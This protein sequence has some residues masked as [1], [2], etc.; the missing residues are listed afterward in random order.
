MV[1]AVMRNQELIKKLRAL[2]MSAASFLFLQFFPLLLIAA[3]GDVIF[4]DDF[5]RATL[6]ADWTVDNSG[7]GD[8]GISAQTANSGTRSLY[9]RWNIVSVTSKSFDLSAVAGAELAIWVRRGDDAFSEDPDNNEDITVE[10]LNNVG[11]WQQLA[12]YVGND[13]PGQIFTPTFYLP[14]GALHSGFQIRFSQTGGSGS[15]WDYWH[16]DDVILTETAG[17]PTLVF[18][19]CDDFESGMN[20]WQVLTAGGDAGT[21]TY[22]FNSASNSLYL[23]WGVVNVTSFDIDLSAVPTAYLNFWLRRGADS[24]SEDPDNN[25]DF[26]VEYFNNSGVWTNLETF[27]GNGSAGEIFNRS[28]LLPASALHSAFKVRFSMSGGS[29]SDWDYWHVDDVCVEGPPAPAT[30][31]ALYH[32]DEASWGSVTDSSGNGNDGAVVGGAVPDNTSPAVAGNP[33]TCGYADIPFNDSDNTYDAI[34]TGID[35]DSGIGNTGT[36]DFWYKSNANWNGNNGDRQLLDASTTSSGQKYF[37]LTLQNNSRLRFGLE[38]SSDGDYSFQGGNNNFA[39]DAWVHVAVTWD[40]PNDVLQIYIN[41]SLDNQQTFSTNG[42]L[43]NMDT[44][45]LGDNRSTYQVGGMTGNSANGSIDEVRI[46]DFV[47]SQ[48]EIQTDMN[49][50]HPCGS[51]LDH[52]VITHDGL[53]INC[54]AE[55]ITVTASQLDGSTYT[56]YTGSIV[57]DTQST[58]GT[59]TL[60]TGAALNFA[61]VMADDGLAT[62]TF[63]AADNGVAI[64]DLDYQSGTA[65]I[66]VDVYDGVIRDDDVEGNLVFSPS[67]FTVTATAL[68]NPPPGVIDTS[69]PAQTAASDFQLYLAAYGATPTDPTCGIIESYTGPQ[70]IKFWS[71]F[72]NPATG[73]LQV[74]VDGGNVAATEA[75]SVAQAVTFTSGQASIT[76]NYPDV[77]EIRLEMKDD[78]TSNPDFL[79][80]GRA[81]IDGQSSL[82]VVKP[83]GFVLDSIVGNPGTATDENGA[84]FTAAGS[85]FPVTVTA[86]NSLSNATPNYGQESTPESVLLTPTLVA[87]GAAN[88]PP[89]GFTTGFDGFVAGVDTG[90]DFHWDE[91]GIITLTPSVGDGDYLG[92]GDVNGTVSANVGRFYP[93]HFATNID[94][95]GSFANICVTAIAFTYLGESFGYLT[96]PTVTVS[97][98]SAHAHMPDLPLANYTGVWAKLGVGGVGL[99]YPAA[100][101]SQLDENGVLTIGVISTVG[102]LGRVDNADGTLTF[103]LGSA[104]ADSFVYVRDAGQV[105]PFTSDLT[106]A[107]TVVDDGEATAND[108]PRNITLVGNQQRFGRGYAQDVYG[109]MSQVDDSL[110]VPIGSWYFN[111][112]GGWTQNTDDTCSIYNYAKVDTNIA[113]TAAPASPVTLASGVGDLTL[114][115]TDGGSPGGNS[116]VTTVW[117]A[118][119]Q[120]DYDGDD[121]PTPLGDGNFY[122]DNPSAT[123]TFGIFRGD[124]RY[125]YW[126]E[127]P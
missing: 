127:A 95:D 50:T 11:S 78:T 2:L 34:D 67:G 80:N 69:I 68:S 24:F 21:G 49:T 38:D 36:I 31:L 58:N 55:R 120:Y 26:S 114:T 122:D 16:V 51:L 108:T 1:K 125:L 85:N 46:Y 37:F 88:N 126:R 94:S 76:V 47:L 90:T 117:P 40:L 81:G 61:D 43:G 98:M 12:R 57:L 29:G 17:L 87:A 48:A 110:I 74:A 121:Q 109:T 32:L 33:G 72:N 59:W 84:M 39:A 66:D 71:V 19:F 92:A 73:S 123:A 41:G 54:L 99:T 7:G 79:L 65:S 100:D 8:T 10:Y 15:N 115:L 93:D 101:N 14:A 56:G 112:S 60:N 3:P 4:N 104:G 44:L 97:A 13:T 35:V 103:T 28:Y 53:G 20:N 111:A 89:I 27:N 9:T 107:L 82:F 63:D 5:E 75:A 62:Y 116:V 119:L 22:T 52:F 83:A 118:W 91:V 6:G 106:I 30:P 25:E 105:A 45:Y 42:V 77:G 64:F 113:A 102:T 23:R 96:D 70:N 18:P 124:D 86:V